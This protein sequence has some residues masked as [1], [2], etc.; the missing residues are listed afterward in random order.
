MSRA[1]N[2]PGTTPSTKNAL[3]LEDLG[4][5]PLKKALLFGKDMSRTSERLVSPLIII[6]AIVFLI[7]DDKFLSDCCHH[8]HGWGTPSVIFL[9]FLVSGIT[10]IIQLTF[11]NHA[12]Q[13]QADL[14]S[15]IA[16]PAA[17]QY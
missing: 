2:Q 16:E 6:I 15:R 5:S 3:L 8:S 17:W 10:V 11:T 1:P 12:D 4:T 14:K 9:L 7:L 13:M